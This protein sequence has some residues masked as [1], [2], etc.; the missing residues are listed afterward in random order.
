M[1]HKKSWDVIHLNITCCIETKWLRL[2]FKA[3]SCIDGTWK[4]LWKSPNSLL[5]LWRGKSEFLRRQE[6]SKDWNQCLLMLRSE[7]FPPC[8][9]KKQLPQWLGK[10]QSQG[11]NLSSMFR[12]SLILKPEQLLTEKVPLGS[13]WSH[14]KRF[15]NLTS[16]VILL[17]FRLTSL[18]L[19]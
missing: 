13:C 18:A 5:L 4:G 9:R 15:S 17:Y 3:N 12:K 10:E 14:Q 1:I 11:S 6:Q 7:L 19:T 2:V 8:S 16:C